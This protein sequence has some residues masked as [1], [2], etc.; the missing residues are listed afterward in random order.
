MSVEQISFDD[1]GLVPGIVQDADD[2]RVLMLAW[3]NAEA[4]Q[5][6]LTTGLATFWS[7]SRS[8]LWVKGATSGNTQQVVE[9]DLD[10]DG[11]TLLIQVRPAG[12]AC[13]TGDDTCFDA[14]TLTAA[15]SR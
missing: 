4:V 3:L 5:A 2:G 12:P 15:G 13:H 14:R 6:T 1:R 7:R 10:C 9:V 8:E 11:D